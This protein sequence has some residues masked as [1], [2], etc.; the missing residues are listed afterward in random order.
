MKMSL[1]EIRQMAG[2]FADLFG[3]GSTCTIM[4]ASERASPIS[5][6]VYPSGQRTGDKYVHVSAD[7]FEALRAAVEAKAVDYTQAHRVMV[8]G[9]I[10]VTA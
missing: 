9:D 1:E 5:C 6:I 7:G 3:K 8:A 2:E 4:V 10:L